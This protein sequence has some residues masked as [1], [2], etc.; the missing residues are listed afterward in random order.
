MSD[1]YYNQSDGTPAPI[2]LGPS[3]IAALTAPQTVVQETRL[4]N[5]DTSDVTYYYFGDAAI[6]SANSSAAWKIS[7]M[8]KA[9]PYLLRYA[10]GGASTCVWNDRTSLTYS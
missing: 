6:G 1:F 3:T 5:I 7:R 2:E 10:T 9:A 4:S 8:T